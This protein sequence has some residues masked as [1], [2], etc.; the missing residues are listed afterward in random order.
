M[1]SIY[2]ISVFIL[3]VVLTASSCS[4]KKNTFMTRN[5]RAVN[6]EFNALYNGNL[7]LEQGKRTLA[8]NYTDDFWEILP[9]ERVKLMEYTA[10][11][12]E[13]E[14][15]DFARAEEKAVKAVQKH[16]I[17]IHGKEYNPQIDEAYMLLGKAR[18]YDSRFIPA[19]E[20]FNFVLNKYPT[21]NS[22]NTAKIWKEKTNI[23]LR[24]EDLALKNLKE[25]FE[26]SELDRED[27]VD[28]SA[29]IAQAYINKEHADSAIVHIKN[30]VEYTKDYEQK[31]RLLYIKGQLYN[32]L[33]DK[34]S[35]NMA[36]DEVIALNRRSPRVYMIN[37][38][39]EKAR[40]FDY[41]KGDKDLLLEHLTELS[42]DRENRP[43]LDLIFHQIGN[44]HRDL[45]DV[46][47]AVAN[48]NKSIK[49]FRQNQKLQAFNY[50]AM[51]DIFFDRA[52]YSAAGAYYDSTLMRLEPNTRLQRQ[53]QKKRDNLEDVITY[54]AIAQ[55]NDSILRFAAMS[56]PERRAYFTEYANNLKEKAIA[57]SIAT[58]KERETF[59][60]DEFFRGESSRA[61]DKTSASGGTFYF[62]NPATVSYGKQEFRRR[63]GNRTSEDDW[64]RS[65][66]KTISQQQS[67]I[68]AEIS[69]EAGGS[70][71]DNPLFD[72]ETYLALIPTDQGVI[73]SLA[74]ER[75]MAYY[76]LGIIYQE[77]FKEYQ[78]AVDRLEKLLTF[79]PE[80]RLVV[81]TKYFLYKLYG[82]L[83]NGVNEQKYRNDI[84]SNHPDSRYAEIINNPAAALATDESSPE[85][86][87]GELYRQFEAQ[88]YKYV[89]EKADEYIYM[90]VGEEILPKFE[91]LKATAIGRTSGLEAYKEALNYV[92][93]NYPNSEEGKRAQA[94]YST[95]IPKL[96][97]FD[98]GEN[99]NS[100]KWKLVYEFS[101]ENQENAEKLKEKIE[102]AIEEKN[103]RHLSA[104]LD[105]Y[106]QDKTF[107]VIHGFTAK[108][109]SRSFA[110]MLKHD[111][112]HK[113][114][115]ESYQISSPN[116]TV[117]QV[118]KNFD[119]YNQ[120]NMN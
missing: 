65:D 39:M 77:K 96:E 93:L 7:A 35:A 59:R 88:Q 90:Y 22:I 15:S 91:L 62:Y 51:G 114:T 76:Q 70:I 102:E 4:R 106:T 87:Y 53:I 80:E 56:E 110:E 20:A 98:F 81:P 86:K 101:T 28:A 72:P 24:N 52:E 12:G 26:K 19:L 44:Y 94:V 67:G 115:Q 48:Y 34:D 6:A 57:D 14:N 112:K 111:K 54:E 23:R 103:Y 3:V 13:E 95:T 8:Q 9:V 45:D 16:S 116:Y 10:I 82:I 47:N 119:A 40:N 42:E 78:L 5:F 29:M 97:I 107:V 92:S 38:E 73:D 99:N 100:D 46:E 63:W 25:L 118:H 68:L 41:E 64:R 31:G 11:M 74:K 58:A 105:Y 33:K 69:A 75:N 108:E 89:I 36:F 49:H 43:F 50:I 60:N 84:V 37:A 32:I 83:E 109:T 61:N 18:Y 1:K 27:F 113:I 2:K 17:E 104:S 66:K 55:V 71:A 117:V 79:S 21:S 120:Q 30:A 85:Y